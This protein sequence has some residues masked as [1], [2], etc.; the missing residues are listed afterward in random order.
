MQWV[1]TSFTVF[2]KS[3]GEMVISPLDGNAL[4]F[5]FGGG[6]EKRNDGD[7]I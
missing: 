4:W 7:P 3:N 2:D 1:N 5:G 6:C